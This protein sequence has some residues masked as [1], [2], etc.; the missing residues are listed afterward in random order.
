MAMT[1]GQ[2]LRAARE[3]KRWSQDELAAKAFMSRSMITAIETGRR[4]PS[5]TDAMALDAALGTGDV[6]T[7]F[8]PK[9]ITGTVPGWFEQAREFERQATFIREF[10]PCWVPG[11]LQTE[12]YARAVFDVGCPRGSAERRHKLLVSRLERA[13]LLDN[14]DTPEVW[15]L[16][17]EAVIRRPIGGYAVMAEQLEHL[18]DLADS[19]RIRV[20]VV[21]FGPLPYPMMD[22]LASLM[23]FE[24]QP[25]VVYTEG[26]HVGFVHDDPATVTAIQ[27]AYDQSLG[28]ALALKPSVALIR[29]QAREFRKRD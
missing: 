26:V 14:P 24:D 25:P 23:W 4:F 28:E 20:H 29:A 9:R 12:E 10:A 21:P 19:G 1:Y 15:A 6:L 2:W 17:D 27:A 22:G 13:G 11:F 8:R 16:M 7:T 18:A 3:A 5:E